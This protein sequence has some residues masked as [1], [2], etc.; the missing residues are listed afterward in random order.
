[1]STGTGSLARR[2]QLVAAAV[3]AVLLT[4]IFVPFQQ[5]NAFTV[6][7]D[8]PDAT[9]V[10][11]EITGSISG[12]PFEITIDVA[13][14]EL[15]SVDA[16]TLIL[17]NDEASVK[18]T[19]FDSEGVYV[20]GDTN[21]VVDNE[22][23]ISA[24]ADGGYAYGFGTVTDGITG[25]TGYSFNFVSTE[26]FVGNNNVGPDDPS[27]DFVIGLLG[28][29]TISINGTIRTSDLA[30]GTHT[31]DVIV[32]S[33]AGNEPD[34]ITFDP[35]FEFE[36]TADDDIVVE[37][38]EVTAGEQEADM[39]ILDPNINSGDPI[40]LEFTFGNATGAT[41]DI[42]VS[43]VST[44][45]ALLYDDERLAELG[46]EIVGDNVRL[47]SDD[48][49][50]QF[51]AVGFIMDIDIS[52]LN[53]PPGTEVTLSLEYDDTDLSP[54]EEELV[55]LMHFD[56]DVQE[57]E[58]LTN[59]N[60][61]INGGDEVDTALNFVFGTTGDFSPFAPAV[62]TEVEDDDDDDDGGSSGG[63]GGGGGSRSVVI[64]WPTAPTFDAEHFVNF[65]LQRMLV[66]SSAFVNAG[67]VSIDAAQTGQQ[68][69][70]SGSFTNQQETAQDY[71]FIVQ[72]EDE[73]GFVTDIAWQQGT[74]QSGSTAD[75]S[76]LWT[77]QTESTFT[78]KIFVWN[79]V[80][81]A[82]EP[83]SEVTV[84]NIQVTA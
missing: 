39:T 16:V 54:A 48:P 35:P 73:D 59:D 65:P 18:I 8:L 21:L 29:G 37:E 78:V 9:G 82:P 46:L 71:A 49:D 58:A 40:F 63:G 36:V 4:V 25:Q 84:K 44:A 19:D 10:T 77:P 51:I 45:A 62:A 33:G 83:L 24:L 20:D 5:A 75:V 1:L 69:S 81:A 23:V 7:V 30:D 11:N 70:I 12:E 15:I 67:G 41:G 61:T 13:A 2:K 6:T 50:M 52:A 17:D 47:I 53:L 74:L 79:G 42:T 57:W 38:E 56:D 72:I 68:I 34:E 31:L 22:I 80:S 60:A 76:T 3:A 28:P 14:G 43:V 32:N 64:T 66:G 55:R 26:D 27:N